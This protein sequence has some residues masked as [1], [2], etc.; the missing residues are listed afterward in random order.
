MAWINLNEL[1]VTKETFD[2]KVADLEGSIES[3]Q[4]SVSH[5]VLWE[6]SSGTRGYYMDASQ[7]AGL[8]EPVS[9]QGRGIVLRWTALNDDY[10][11]PTENENYFQF[12]PKLF[13]AEFEGKGVSSGV[14]NSSIGGVLGIKYVYV[15]DNR[16]TGNDNNSRNEYTSVPGVKLTPRHWA[17]SA[18]YGV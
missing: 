8:S 7:Q 4:D 16:I 6:R 9:S 18:V 17:L 3:L 15:Y 2:D 1:Y 13:V 10:S 5:K 12:V 14:M 11:G